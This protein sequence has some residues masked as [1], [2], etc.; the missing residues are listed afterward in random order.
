MFIVSNTSFFDYFYKIY[1][2]KL[3]QTQKTI[4]TIKKVYFQKINLNTLKILNAKKQV[5][6]FN[7]THINSKFSKFKINI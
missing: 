5:E 4:G 3:F 1:K 6:D 2:L 7:S